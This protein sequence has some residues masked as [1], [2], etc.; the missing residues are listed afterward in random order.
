MGVFHILV[1]YQPIYTALILYKH[2]LSII[3]PSLHNHRN[4]ALVC[5]LLASEG[6]GNLLTFC[7]KFV[8][9]MTKRSQ[10]TSQL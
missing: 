8:T 9:T 7:P 10:E 5:R 3:F 2:T 4:A 1:Q 6:R